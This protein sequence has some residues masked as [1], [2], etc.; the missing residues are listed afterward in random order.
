MSLE[1]VYNHMDYV[2][3]AYLQFCLLQTD[4]LIPQLVKHRSENCDRSWKLHFTQIGHLVLY[5]TQMTQNYYCLLFLYSVVS[6]VHEWLNKLF[7][8]II[9]FEII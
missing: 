6:H 3:A 9:A 7:V 1:I 4:I 2:P 5:M 8:V